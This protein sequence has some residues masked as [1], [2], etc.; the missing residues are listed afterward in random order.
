MAT[1]E[2]RLELNSIDQ[3]FQDPVFDP[4]TPDS[5][6]LSGIDELLNQMHEL[7]GREL[8]AM[9]RL[10]IALPA[11][12]V[13]PG[14]DL[15]VKQA[16]QRYCDEMI[17]QNERDLR[18]VRRGGRR[19]LPYSLVVIVLG[20]GVVYLVSQLLGSWSTE[21]TVF[22]SGAL[23]ILAWVA[24]WQPFQAFIYDWIPYR[25]SIAILEHLRSMEVV[26]ATASS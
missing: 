22:L 23:S 18:E 17:A 20:T 4:F 16:L 14:L 12:A 9:R 25:R 7:S 26:I 24:L 2:I 10:A 6:S 11:G 1:G 21:L 19:Q 5:R 8:E 13:A 3:L 15:E